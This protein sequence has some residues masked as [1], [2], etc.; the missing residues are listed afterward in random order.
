[1]SAALP[2]ASRHPAD[3]APVARRNRDLSDCL[4]DA[5]ARLGLQKKELE[6][7][8]RCSHQFVSQVLDGSKPLTDERLA[9]LPGH[10]QVAVAQEWCAELGLLTGSRA[11][12]IGALEAARHLLALPERAERMAKAGV[13]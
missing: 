11:A 6:F 8:W 1:M 4:A 13:E 3:S 10:I 5:L 12:A 9:Q 7:W 2:V